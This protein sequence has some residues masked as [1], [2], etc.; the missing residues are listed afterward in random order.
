MGDLTGKIG[1]FTGKIC[2]L[3]DKIC[4][5]TCKI[6]DWTGKM[7]DSTDDSTDD[8]GSSKAFRPSFYLAPWV[9]K[10]QGTS[11]FSV[12]NVRNDMIGTSL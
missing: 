4:D 3:T 9:A 5:L 6:G 12:W 11:C 7:D 8:Q 1:D 10:R 2:D